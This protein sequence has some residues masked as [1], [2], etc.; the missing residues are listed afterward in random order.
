MCVW[1]RWA[2]FGEA[3]ALPVSAVLATSAL[4]ITYFYVRTQLGVFTAVAV[5]AVPADPARVPVDPATQ[6]A[7][8]AAP[9][10]GEEPSS[11]GSS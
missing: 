10:A 8:A 3:I 6:G 5:P 11:G 9:A 4:T 2:V 1:Y 7:A